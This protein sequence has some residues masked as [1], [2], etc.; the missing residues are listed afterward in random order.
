MRPVMLRSRRFSRAQGI[1]VIRGCLFLAGAVLWVAFVG[2]ALSHTAS[3]QSQVPW[4][5]VGPSTFPSRIL[6]LVP[7][8]RNDSVL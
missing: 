6:S 2:P 3:A 1:R 5:F 4:S 8:P 7:D